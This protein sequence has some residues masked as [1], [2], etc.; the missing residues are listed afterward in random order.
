M[1]VCSC[2]VCSCQ[3]TNIHRS[4]TPTKV[5]LVDSG[6]KQSICGRGFTRTSSRIE[7]SQSQCV[8]L[9]RTYD[10]HL[11]LI[12]RSTKSPRT[13]QVTPSRSRARPA[14]APTLTTPSRQLRARNPQGQ[15]QSIPSAPRD[16][17][18]PCP[19]AGLTRQSPAASIAAVP[20]PPLQDEVGVGPL[21]HP[22]RVG[23]QHLLGVHPHA[24][25]ADKGRAPR[26][27]SRTAAAAAAASDATMPGRRA[28][29]GTRRRRMG[30][31]RRQ[32]HALGAAAAAG[33]GGA[34]P[35][36]AAAAPRAAVTSTAAAHRPTARPTA[37]TARPTAAPS[38]AARDTDYVK[39]LN[40]ERGVIQPQTFHRALGFTVGA[41]CSW[42]LVTE[43][44]LPPE[45]AGWG[46][47][48][49]FAPCHGKCLLVSLRQGNMIPI[50]AQKGF[51]SLP[52]FMVKSY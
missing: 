6:W 52:E 51:S 47:L 23:Q 8:I 22:Q 29:A 10:L 19:A 20:L 43:R 14:L 27:A 16:A 21:R 41:S 32:P 26:G 11:G 38:R 46:A 39:S 7:R 15:P 17:A 18:G 25:A 31:R 40:H 42:C 13:S 3:A 1:G 49:T 33:R 45:A 30:R 34:A 2:C 50:G 48:L 37:A 44:W 9:A 28:A 5:F 35:A 24:P 4:Q 12:L 36:A